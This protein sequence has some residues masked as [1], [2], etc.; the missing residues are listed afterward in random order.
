MDSLGWVLEWAWERLLVMELSVLALRLRLYLGIRCDR[1]LL[2]RLQQAA[3]AL[4]VALQALSVVYSA[5]SLR[6]RA[7]D[8]R[9]QL[10]LAHLACRC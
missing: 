5:A 6:G 2:L 7:L 8:H 10:Q 1:T 4:P 9:H 3:D